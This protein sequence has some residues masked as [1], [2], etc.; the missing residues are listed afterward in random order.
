MMKMMMD[1][2]TEMT[3]MS[4]LCE[5]RLKIDK[6]QN[7]GAQYSKR[8]EADPTDDRWQFRIVPKIIVTNATATAIM[9]LSSVSVD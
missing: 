6:A 8:S 2:E 7:H 1:R 3:S 5:W 4:K 9:A